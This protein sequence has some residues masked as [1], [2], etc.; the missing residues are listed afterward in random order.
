MKGLLAGLEFRCDKIILDRIDV[1]V[2]FAILCGY[3]RP[4]SVAGE[5]ADSS[6]WDLIDMPL[7]TGRL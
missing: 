1:G 3:S 7:L 5:I 6:G 4:K 2:G